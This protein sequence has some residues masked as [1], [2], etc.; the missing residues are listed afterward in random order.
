M[1][2]ILTPQAAAV[3]P[4][5]TGAWAAKPSPLGSGARPTLSHPRG[6]GGAD[7]AQQLAL[8]GRKGVGKGG[9]E[10]G[11][12]GKERKEPLYWPPFPHSNPREQRSVMQIATPPPSQSHHHPWGPLPL[13]QGVSVLSGC[14]LCAICLPYTPEGQG[15][16][17]LAHSEKKPAPHPNP[18]YLKSSV[19][20]IHFTL[21][22]PLP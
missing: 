5:A 1:D 19:F 10:R 4:P 22:L 14:L 6:I 17:G 8:E 3:A 21:I 18:T 16:L 7:Q 15:P 2:F 12:V 9:K 11:G 20:G 13:P